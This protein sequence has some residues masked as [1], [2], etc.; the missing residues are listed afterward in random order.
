M[1]GSLENRTVSERES[2]GVNTGSCEGGTLVVSMRSN[3]VGVDP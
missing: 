3:D 1:D 2:R